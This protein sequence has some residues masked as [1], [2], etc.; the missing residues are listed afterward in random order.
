[1]P[2]N[3]TQAL[4]LRTFDFR[5]TS[6]IVSFY[7]KDFG[8]IHGILKGIRT[9]PDKFASTLE[10]FSHN[11][12]IFYQKKNAGLHLVSACDL[13]NNFLS[14]RNDMYRFGHASFMMELLDALTPLEDKNEAIFDL[15]MECLSHMDMNINYEKI[16]T[17][18]KIK[19]LSLSGFKPHL[20]SCVCCND[21]ILSQSKFSN[22]LGGLLCPRCFKKDVKAT[23]IFR[24]TVASISYIEKNDLS[25]N[26]RLGLNP[27]I[28]RELDNLLN[29]FIEFHLEKKLKT[30]R[31]LPYL[32]NVLEKV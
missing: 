30:Q 3:K 13:K 32:E 20:N 12:I 5:E 27:Q 29:S 28:K 1:M 24:G 18:Y 8:K 17:I 31:V 7:T 11:E 14:L 15:T 23:L 21:R 16:P 2:I 22:Y 25:N 10:P 19:I 9:E 26:L 6:L 4:V